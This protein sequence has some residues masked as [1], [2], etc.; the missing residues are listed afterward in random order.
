MNF[1]TPPSSMARQTTAMGIAAALLGTPRVKQTVRIVS[2]DT[3]HGITFYLVAVNEGPERYR[4]SQA[5]LDRLYAGQSPQSLEL[6]DE[7]MEGPFEPEYPV[8]DRA[9]SAADCAYQFN[10]E[11]L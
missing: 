4:V 11:A 2:R 10:K 3:L 9:S 1:R 6:E 5:F 7:P 8:D